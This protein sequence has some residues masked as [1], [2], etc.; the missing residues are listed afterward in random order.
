MA[1]NHYDNDEDRTTLVRALAAIDRSSE[2]HKKI[3]DDL[4]D[5]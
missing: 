3:Y 5:E 1:A 2:E 4:A